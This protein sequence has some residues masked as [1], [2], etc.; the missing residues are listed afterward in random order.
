MDTPGVLGLNAL[1]ATASRRTL[2]RSSGPSSGCARAR[3]TRPG[4]PNTLIT[5][6]GSTLKRVHTGGGCPV[7]STLAFY[8]HDS[9][10]TALVGGAAV[11][12]TVR[13][14]PAVKRPIAEIPESVWKTI[15]Y[16]GTRLRPGK[17][18]Y[19]DWVSRAEI[20]ETVFPQKDR[21]DHR[22]PGRAPDPAVNPEGH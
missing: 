7:V 5:D 16:T 18:N 20:A 21:A 12:V 10:A 11:S 17:H 1:L 22:P 2:P 13:M 4:A 8:G 15:E 6:A 14:H 19:E 9:V 3:R